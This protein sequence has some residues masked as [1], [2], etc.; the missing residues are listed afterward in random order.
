[1]SENVSQVVAS[2]R[3]TGCSACAGCRHITLRQGSLGFPVPVI[4]ETCERC[5]QCLSRCIYAPENDE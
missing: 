5:G 4:D 1:M 2:G 3:C